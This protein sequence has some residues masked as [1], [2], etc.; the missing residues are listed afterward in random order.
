MVQ[1]TVDLPP[2]GIVLTVDQNKSSKTA[3][4]AKDQ[5]NIKPGVDQVV[6]LSLSNLC[7]GDLQDGPDFEFAQFYCL[8]K[9]PPDYE[10]RRIPTLYPAD[11]IVVQSPRFGDCFLGAM[12]SAPSP[13]KSQ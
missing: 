7:S 2:D 8:L 11:K 10:D 9:D 6:V 4:A 1:I 12:I 3:A 5:I 13:E